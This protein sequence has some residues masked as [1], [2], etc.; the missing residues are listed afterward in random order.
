MDDKVELYV[1]GKKYQGFTDLTLDI[2]M[3]AISKKFELTLTDNWTH[4]GKEWF[5][6]PER[7]CELKIN[8]KTLIKGFIDDVVPSLKSNTIVITGRDKTGDLVDC[9]VPSD[10]NEY[11]EVTL[12]KLCEILCLPFSI[13]VTDNLNNN[14]IFKVFKTQPGEKIFKALERA[15]KVR[16]ALLVSDFDGNLVI[17]KKSVKKAHSFLKEGVN[18]YDG[19]AT[20]SAKERF[21]IYT[22]LGQQAGNDDLS[23]DDIANLKETA[24][25]EGI[26]RYRPLTIL[27]EKTTNKAELKKR[28][29]WEAIKRAADSSKISIQTQGWTQE[30]GDLWN[31]NELIR[32][33]SPFLGLDIDLL[34]TEIKFTY[35]D[36][37]TTFTLKRKD[38]FEPKP[39][40]TKESKVEVWKELE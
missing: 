39:T 30:N 22:A 29:E 24:T 17:E 14:E 28:V 27:A 32:V 37:L 33:E 34:I 12:L 26:S 38:S 15:A 6:A 16:G 21:S 19:T 10:K 4:N 23:P 5:F 2:S 35:A 20:Y 3:Q 13:M 7:A 11:R 1:L 18:I 9:S 31:I 25:D 8:D 36:S 40:I